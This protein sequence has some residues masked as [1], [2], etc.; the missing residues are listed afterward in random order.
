MKYLILLILIPVVS[1]SQAGDTSA[2]TVKQTDSSVADTRAALSTGN[3]IRAHYLDLSNAL[4]V[5]AYDSIFA[6]STRFTTKVDTGRFAVPY[7]GFA[8]LPAYQ[9]SI[10]VINP[11]ISSGSIVIPAW[12]NN[13]FTPITPLGSPVVR[14]Y[15]G[16][17]TL[18]STA[19]ESSNQVFEYFIIHY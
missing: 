4:M 17:F 5:G 16:Y 14:C 12:Y 13:V 18:K 3:L 2:Y 8:S 6:F 11:L 1:W 15:T 19:V 9:D 7:V 10:A